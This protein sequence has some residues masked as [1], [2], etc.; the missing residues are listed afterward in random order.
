[1]CRVSG[2]RVSLRGS[3]WGRG[4][5]INGKAIDGRYMTMPESCLGF[6]TAKAWLAW[7]ECSALK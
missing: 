4:K 2:D 3:L 7:D 1:M 5:S 6:G